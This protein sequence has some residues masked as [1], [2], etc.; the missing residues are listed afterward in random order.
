M[1]HELPEAQVRRS[2]KLEGST[3]THGPLPAYLECSPP[4]DEELGT[5]GWTVERL[6]VL[7]Q[8]RAGV[9]LPL[10]SLDAP[11]GRGGRSFIDWLAAG[12]FSVWQILPTG[13]TGLDRSPYFARSDFAGNPKFLDQAQQPPVDHLCYT[14]F[15]NAAD[16]WLED[17]VLFEV[18]SAAHGGAA[19][20][21][22]PADLR[23]RQPAALR[24]VIRNFSA[25]MDHVRH[26]QYAFFVQWNALRRY[27]HSRGVR[28]FGDLPFYLSP[29]SAET[30]ARRIQFQL[31]AAGRAT[32]VSGMPADDCCP[33]GQIWH[34]PLYNW[35][36]MQ[37]DRFAYWRARVQHS[38]ERVDL[39]RI[40]HF[41]ALAAHWVIPAGADARGGHWC[42]TP[43]GELLRTLY[44]DLGDLP[45]VVEDLG[46]LTEDAIALRRQFCL[47]GMRV[48]QYAFDGT[49][50]NPHLPWQHALESI[51]YSS[52]HDTDTVLGWYQNLNPEA[53]ERVD[54][55]LR[56]TS[57]SMPEALIHEALSSDG[58][59]AVIAVQD[60]L[61]LGSA[62]RMNTPGTVFGNNWRWHLSADALT[63]QQAR[64]WYRI[65]RL[66]GRC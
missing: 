39:L 27:A 44:D 11:L 42:P 45:V 5:A 14:A 25:Q 60:L 21:H 24:R 51:V 59:L 28:V 56:T 62:A 34:H 18:L 48:L 57:D 30:W 1:R 7:D 53:R 20:W 40:D 22:W 63:L 9:L 23:D 61:G 46:M 13:P 43:G 12:G 8:R 17:H 65:N 10:A 2:W 15:L 41:Q 52:T 16:H 66:H 64:H 58:R 3:M 29:N 50:D 54:R 37:H 19:W 33:D 35:Q 6:P 49:D 38:L 26:K 4:A 47:P 36:G 32:A 55:M 31:D